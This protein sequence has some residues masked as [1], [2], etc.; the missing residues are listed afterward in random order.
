[1]F[2][3]WSGKISRKMQLNVCKNQ[4]KQVTNTSKVYFDI[5]LI[6]SGPIPA[7]G[8]PRVEKI[9][10][11]LSKEFRIIALGWDRETNRYPLAYKNNIVIKH[12][13]LK[14]PYGKL[15]II[16][17]YPIFWIWIFINLFIYRPKAIYS[18]N[19]DTLIPS[20]IFKTLFSTKLIF[21]SFDKF[22]MAFISPNHRIVYSFIDTL[23]NLLASKADALITVSSDRLYTFGRFKPRYYGII[24]NCPEDKIKRIRDDFSFIKNKY[25]NYFILVYAGAI[26][27]NRGLLLLDQVIKNIRNVRLILAGR[28]RENIEFILKNPN[29]EY[30]GVLEYDKTL[31]LMSI[32]DAIP[33][34]YDPEV[35]INQVANPNKLFEA[36]MLGIPV[37]TNVCKEIIE[38]SGCGLVVEYNYESLKQAIQYFID[39]PDIRK[40]MGSNGRKAFEEKYNWNIMEK[41]LLKI[42]RK[43]IN[44]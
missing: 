22:A 24:M 21:D 1:M 28:I 13:R 42:I 18:C 9:L 30:L 31:S 17:Y 2:N 35:P 38:E 32:A 25:Y 7:I 6:R 14:A 39:Q 34:L 26:R 3:K 5:A 43:T 10:K 44:E 40:K 19:L 8:D 29:I 4:N 36:M 23:E 27:Y 15:W 20:Y 33:I 37:I 16:F 12:I 11:S 41:K